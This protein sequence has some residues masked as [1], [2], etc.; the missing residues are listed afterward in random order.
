MYVIAKEEGIRYG[1]GKGIVG[2]ILRE[3][4]YSTIR[5][6]GYEPIKVELFGETDPQTCPMWKRLCAGIISGCI[7][8]FATQPIELLKT[9][10]QGAPA[11]AW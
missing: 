5:L 8:S 6:G 4:S 3:A 1:I 9:R 2:Q 7:G 10:V 11:G